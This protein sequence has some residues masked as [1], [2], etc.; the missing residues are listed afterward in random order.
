MWTVCICRRAESNGKFIIE[1]STYYVYYESPVYEFKVPNK[2]LLLFIILLSIT[3]IYI[4][5]FSIEMS[6]LVLTNEI[7]LSV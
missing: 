1:K 3:Y 2:Y 7:F 6:L 5:V 4:H